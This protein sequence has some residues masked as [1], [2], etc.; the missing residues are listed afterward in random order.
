MWSKNCIISP[1]KFVKNIQTIAGQKDRDIFTGW[2]QNDLPEFLL[3][4]FESFNEALSSKVSVLISGD[5][6]NETDQLAKKSYN[7]IKTLYEKEY[8]PLLDLFYGI[9]VTTITNKNGGLLSTVPE[10]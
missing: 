1:G 10:P 7:M 9:S 2:A 4:V 8:S 5:V 6:K 3:F